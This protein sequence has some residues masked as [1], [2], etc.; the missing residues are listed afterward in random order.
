MKPEIKIENGKVLISVSQTGD[1]NNDGQPS[2]KADLSVEIY[3]YELITEI[4]KK[5]L[6]LLELIIAQIKA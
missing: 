1:F 2:I 4:A 5:D 6:P 3:A